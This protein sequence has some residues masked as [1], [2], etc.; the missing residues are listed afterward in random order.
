MAS[1]GVYVL[2]SLTIVLAV[3]LIIGL[4]FISQLT[5]Q[6]HC[7]MGGN[8]NNLSSTVETCT[9]S[10]YSGNK[11]TV[12]RVSVVLIWILIFVVCLL[13]ILAMCRGNMF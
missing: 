2:G 9:I 11:L 3:F 4:V 8:P 10:G 7:S 6:A 1:V 12:A 13:A 5:Y